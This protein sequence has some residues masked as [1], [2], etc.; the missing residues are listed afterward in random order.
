MDNGKVDDGWQMDARLYLRGLDK[1]ILSWQPL[2]SESAG[3]ETTVTAAATA[4][5][6][7]TA[8]AT[9]EDTA[10]IQ[11]PVQE[12]KSGTSS[13]L[14]KALMCAADDDG[15][16]SMRDSAPLSQMTSTG[17]SSADEDDDALAPFSIEHNATGHGFLDSG[18]SEV[19]GGE[20]H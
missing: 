11:A 17:F 12:H 1:A 8:K 5:V 19:A 3:C 4:T 6:T 13:T 2:M 10:P 15:P 18:R 20:T 7:A 14:V 16:P 9:N